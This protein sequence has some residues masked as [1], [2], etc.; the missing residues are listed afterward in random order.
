MPMITSTSIAA[1]HKSASAG[2]T[3]T[4][5]I[6]AQ[7][8]PHVYDISND[9][10]PVLNPGGPWSYGWSSN[11]GSAFIIDTDH[12]LRGN[13]DEW[14]GDLA[15][16]G[17]PGVYHNGTGHADDSFGV[18]F[19]TNQTI[20]HPGPNGEYAVVRWTA[21]AAGDYLIQAR[22]SAVPVATT[23]VHVLLNDTS[24][25]D[26]NVNGDVVDMPT[27]NYSPPP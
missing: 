27:P 26:G 17:N 20:I 24:L 8:T 5:T 13:I 2:R 25:F 3:A 4:S 12:H 19:A 18:P 9:F 22:F 1:S 10:S 11:L 7:S 6:A 23:V 15:D 21:P 16:D 14:A